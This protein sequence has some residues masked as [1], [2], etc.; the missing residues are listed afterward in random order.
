MYRS[1]SL[2]EDISSIFRSFDNLLHEPDD[3][4]AL[5]PATHILAPASGTTLPARPLVR[6]WGFAFPAVE[7]FQRGDEIVFR[8]ELSGVDPADVDVQVQDGRLLISGEKKLEHEE[9]E[10]T[11]LRETFHGR[12]QR[13]FA[14]PKGISSDQ[15]KARYENGVLE[16]TLPATGLKEVARKV[17]IQVLPAGEKKKAS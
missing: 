13:V 5:F 16:V 9:D 12:F 4:S 2:L 7:F 8:A 6:R 17:P 14:L 10:P 1:T 11:F 15:V 3:E